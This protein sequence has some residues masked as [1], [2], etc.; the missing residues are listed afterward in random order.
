MLTGTSAKHFPPWSPTVDSISIKKLLPDHSL[1]AMKLPATVTAIKFGASFNHSID[2]LGSLPVLQ[3]IRFDEL[4]SPYDHPLYLE[5]FVALTR[6][7]LPKR[8]SNTMKLPVSLVA[9]AFPSDSKYNQPLMLA[10]LI[11]LTHLELGKGFNQPPEHFT[12]PSSLA[13]LHFYQ[14]SEFN[15][16]LL[17]SGC[18]RLTSLK[19]GS[20]FTQ[21]PSCFV[22]PASLVNF[23]IY[24]SDFRHQLELSGCCKLQS[25]QLPKKFNHPLLL[26]G[27]TQLNELTLSEDFNQPSNMLQLSDSVSSIRFGVCCRRSLLKFRWPKQLQSLTFKDWSETIGIKSLVT[28]L[29][30]LT[31]LHLQYFDESTDA[32]PIAPHLKYLSLDG[33]DQPLASWLQR[34]PVLM[35]LIIES[36]YHHCDSLIF[37]A[38]LRRLAI[39]PAD[40]NQVAHLSNRLHSHQSPN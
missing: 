28:P 25:L 4:S 7:E 13:L 32:L 2:S 21:P 35:E 17:L 30:T 1:A 19:I 10:D 8:F 22:L 20:R 16:P 18:S 14:H 9:M 3:T 34:L 29:S 5:W 39:C 11:N 6:L 15:H 24:S 26:A 37:P 33:Y 23:R 40:E 12:L 27:C 31:S 36:E 38:S